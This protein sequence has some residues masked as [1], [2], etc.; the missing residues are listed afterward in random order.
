MIPFLEKV[1]GVWFCKGGM[2]S[3]VRALEDVF[4]QL[5][6]VVKTDTEVERIVVENRRAKGVI[7][8]GQFY[9]ADSVISNADSGT[10]LR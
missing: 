2:Y 5:G 10:H 8:N 9:E 4:K 3:L 6:G 1:G 7:A